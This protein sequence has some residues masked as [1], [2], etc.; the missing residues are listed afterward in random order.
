[1]TASQRVRVKAFLNVCPSGLP[2]VKYH[3]ELD[4]RFYEEEKVLRFLRQYSD[5]LIGLKV[6]QSS[7]IVG[8]LGVKPLLAAL[9]IAE[10]AGCSVAC[11]TTNAPVSAAKLVEY[12]RPGDVY[13][14]V[15]HGK[16][17]TIL[18]ESGT[19]MPEV[20]AAQ[21]RGVLFDAASGRSHFSVKVAPAAVAQ[22]FLP[23]IIST[24]ITT[25]NH[26][27]PGSAFSLPYTMSKCLACGMT[28]SDVIERVTL[29]PARFLHQERELG[30]LGCGTCA[31][32]AILSLVEKETRFGDAQGNVLTGSTLLKTQMTI[33][34]GAVVFRQIDF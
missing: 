1:M 14:H 5:Q 33:R 13:A 22:G 2:T 16:G 3:E 19:V 27:M 18:D 4:P 29:A 15:Y 8:E 32:I 34:D 26:W 31:D 11:H 7:E 9:A 21:K 24:D 25:N 17:N 23:D 20:R 28:L 10:K 30:S 12:F 6:R